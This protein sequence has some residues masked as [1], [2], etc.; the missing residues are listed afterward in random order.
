MLC[1]SAFI[2]SH[3]SLRYAYVK[4][5]VSLVRMAVAGSFKYGYFSYKNPSLHF[6]RHL[7]TH[8]SGMVYFYD[9]WRNFLALQNQT[10]FNAITKLGRAR[11]LFNISPIVFG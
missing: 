9:G 3:L 10:L 6:R 11:I 2:S 5:R 1:A 7:L 8:W 4:R